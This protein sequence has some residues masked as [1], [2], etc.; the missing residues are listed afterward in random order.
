MTTPVVHLFCDTN[1]FLQCRELEELDWSTWQGM[2]VRVIVSAPVLKEIDHRKN[3]GNDRVSR[4][5]RK[6]SQR[7]RKMLPVGESVVRE[8]HPRVTL[9]VEPGHHYSFDLKDRLDYSGRD[10]Q[11]VGTVH[12]FARAHQEADV[13]L[14]THD[15]TPLYTAQGLELRAEII[16][17]KWLLPPEEDARGKKIRALEAE[18]ERM[19]R[20]EPS[21][22]VEFLDGRDAPAKGLEAQVFR[23]S[24]L[25]TG[26]KAK[27]MAR[28][29]QRFPLATQFE[30]PRTSRRSN[31]DTLRAMQRIFSSYHPPKEEEIAEYQDD[32]YPKW[33]SRC[34]RRLSDMHTALG[35]QQ[36]TLLGFSFRVTNGGTRPAESVLV[37]VRARGNLQVM[38]MPPRYQPSEPV[39]LPQPPRPPQGSWRDPIAD[40]RSMAVGKAMS[41]LDSSRGLFPLPHATRDPNTFYFDPKRPETPQRA[42]RLTC[43][44]WRHAGDP[45]DFSGVLE[46]PAG[47]ESAEG[48]LE[49]RVEAQNL[50]TPFEHVVPVRIQI[51]TVSALSATLALIDNLKMSEPA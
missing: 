33:L 48:A 19:R 17:D 9:S 13:R 40:L 22:A 46:V 21:F 24:A 5:A 45:E 42:F 43:E 27:A 50:A 31:E 35:K 32:A 41:T 36:D 1:L 14:L 7:F 47:V 16:P 4:R 51:A 49:V 28:L 18:L 26:E 15:T 38:P 11:L 6:A 29:R 20:T 34:E 23:Y 39:T 25:D 8:A 44:Q 3:R 10:D 30:P 2:Q 37:T 12:A